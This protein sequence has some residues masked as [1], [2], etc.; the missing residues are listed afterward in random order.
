MAQQL[1]TATAPNG[2]WT[3]TAITL[4]KCQSALLNN[5][6][7]VPVLVRW[8]AAGSA[9]VRL[10]ASG[11]PGAAR[12]VTWQKTQN[13]TTVGVWGVGGTGDVTIELSEEFRPYDVMPPAATLPTAGVTPYS[14]GVPADWNPQPT[15]VAEG[16]D[17]LALRVEDLETFTGEVLYVDA[18]V[19][20]DANTGNALEPYATV[21]AAINAAIAS[22]QSAIRVILAPGIYA[23]DVTITGAAAAKR[24]ELCGGAATILAGGSLSSTQIQSLVITAG[25]VADLDVAIVGMAAISTAQ[26]ALSFGPSGGGAVRIYLLDSFLQASGFDAL[27]IGAAAGTVTVIYDGTTINALEGGAINAAGGTIRGR[28]R[29]T[30]TNVLAA[31]AAVDLSNAASFQHDGYLGGNI[32]VAVPAAINSTGT[33]RIALGVVDADLTAGAKLIETIGVVEVYAGLVTTRG[34]P[35][36]GD[37]DNPAGT[38]IHGI[39]V[40][41]D[42]SLLTITAGV[43]VLL[44]QAVQTGYTPTT[45]ADWATT[46]TEVS[47][48]LDQ[49]AGVEA[50]AGTT[51]YV[52]GG[53]GNDANPG[54]ALRPF[55]TVQAAVNAAIAAAGNR[56]RIVIAPGNY[57]E[58]VAITSAVATK[59]IDLVG[60]DY[61]NVVIESLTLTAGGAAALDVGILGISLS[62][63]AQST[64]A[65]GASG[66]GACTANMLRCDLACNGF[67]AIVATAAALSVTVTYQDTQI[68][69]TSALAIQLATGVARGRGTITT[70]AA[71]GAVAAVELTNAAE[72][73]HDGVLSAVG[74]AITTGIDNQGTGQVRLREVESMLTAGADLVTCTGISTVVIGRAI[75]RGAGSGAVNNGIGTVI[76]GP[77][78]NEDGTSPTITGTEVLLDAA[79]QVSLDPAAMTIVSAVEVQTAIAQLDTQLSEIVSVRFRAGLSAPQVVNAAATDT[80]IFD[81]EAYDV[82]GAYDNGTGAFTAPTN[83]LYLFQASLQTTAA[84]NSQPQIFVDG[85]VEQTGT[86]SATQLAGTVHCLLALNAAQVVTCRSSDLGGAGH[87]VA[88]VITQSTFEGVR[89]TS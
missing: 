39:C 18:A 13:P 83:G 3:D 87:T 27:A 69:S 36:A 81:T 78:T 24:I 7:S 16:L 14:P 31:A 71:L 61:P 51:L 77:V 17:Q 44:Q 75:V 67:P 6:A 4:G 54:N 47:G 41:E 86:N 53:S 2:S 70:T 43:E 8:T 79:I 73:D 63:A 76:H 59:Q 84:A 20:N 19:G 25:G 50:F 37:I 42:G 66:G 46:P 26:S 15:T 11:S 29:V 9:E 34:A 52:D 55:A 64:L 56:A 62:S 1:I 21:Q 49:L 89:L 45:A 10:E 33:G 74:V 60:G 30:V 72:F 57:A 88:G 48:A 82:G 35:G 40:A 68:A 58:N 28:G 5:R 85:I 22:A 32:A 12:N 65:F 80:V 23:E 38:V